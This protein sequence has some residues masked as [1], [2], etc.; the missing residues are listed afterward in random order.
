M[1]LDC[2]S[3]SPHSTVRSTRAAKG[4]KV[5]I[6]RAKPVRG[7][8][9]ARC[10]SYLYNPQISCDAEF[11]PGPETLSHIYQAREP[12]HEPGC[13]GGGLDFGG[14]VWRRNAWAKT[15][16]GAVDPTN[17]GRPALL[18][19]SDPRRRSVTISDANSYRRQEPPKWPSAA[20]TGCGCGWILAGAITGPILPMLALPSPTRLRLRFFDAGRCRHRL[21]GMVPQP[22]LRRH[23]FWTC[24]NTRIGQTT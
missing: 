1:T 2:A 11:G 5:A 4:C 16:L 21:G 18:R 7:S 22:I 20:R 3:F 17:S 14:A 13:R 8:G 6:E 10:G 19:G 15:L 12:R 23:R 24:T 9:L